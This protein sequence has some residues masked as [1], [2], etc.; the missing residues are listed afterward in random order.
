MRTFTPPADTRFYAGADLHARILFLVILD[1]DAKIVFARNLPAVPEP[2]LRA[3]APFRDR[4]R[5]VLGRSAR[6]RAGSSD[7]QA[8]S[9]RDCPSVADV[10]PGPRSKRPHRSRAGGVLSLD[11]ESL[12][13]VSRDPRSF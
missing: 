1:R 3:V 5:L 11:S 4:L 10:P 13:R 7:S 12:M 8:G 6:S 2:F 9:L